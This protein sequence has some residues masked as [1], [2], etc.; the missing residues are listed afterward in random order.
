[1]RS[2]FCNIQ[3]VHFLHEH[4]PR[5][6]SMAGPEK[7]YGMS[8][9]APAII[10]IAALAI[11]S[12]TRLGWHTGG[13]AC[14]AARS[15]CIKAMPRCTARKAW[16]SISCR[17]PSRKRA[18]TVCIWTCAARSSPRRS[19]RPWHSAPT[20]PMTSTPEGVGRYSA[21]PRAT[22]SAYS[23][24]VHRARQRP[25]HDPALHRRRLRRQAQA[26][27]VDLDGSKNFEELPRIVNSR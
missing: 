19:R 13:V 6:V 10:G 20:K 11:D 18:R 24:L 1:M 22:N 15:R 7:E 17:C 9:E 23:D 12:P 16:R 25:G 14:S 8:E 2:T 26:H 27:R 3:T 4:N 5:P 21:I